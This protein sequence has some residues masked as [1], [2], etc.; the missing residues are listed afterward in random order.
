[1]PYIVNQ[2][3]GA[4][5]SILCALFAQQQRYLYLVIEEFDRGLPIKGL[6]LFCAAGYLLDFYQLGFSIF[7][8]LWRNIIC[9]CSV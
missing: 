9:Q 4:Q 7:K 5:L 6:F 8:F 3:T 2:S 1:M